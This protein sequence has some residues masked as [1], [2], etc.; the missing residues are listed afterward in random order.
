MSYRVFFIGVNE[1]GD[2]ILDYYQIK[3]KT[4]SRPKPG[5]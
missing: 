3:S 4:G 2:N 5:D 1:K